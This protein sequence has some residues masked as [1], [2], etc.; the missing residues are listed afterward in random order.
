MKRERGYA[1]T[2]AALGAGLALFAASRGW[3]E[4]EVRATVPVPLPPKQQTG[5]E[6]LPWLPALALA[7]LAGAGAVLATRGAVRMVVG[8]L[9]LLCG[10]GIVAGAGY[11]VIEGA[12]PWWPAAAALGGLVA[13]D[14]GVLTLVR[15]RSWPAMAARYQRAAQA[16][17]AQ[18]A[19]TTGS[20]GGQP[21]ARP[22]VAM[23]DAL[24]RG[25]DPTR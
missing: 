17:P 6:L 22:S 5:A 4:I 23:W 11:A 18:P 9:L 20:A 10:V 1:A 8:L 19:A 16:E 3:A 15:G 12:T 24:D 14:A 21:P 13:L 2:A 7:A 25:E